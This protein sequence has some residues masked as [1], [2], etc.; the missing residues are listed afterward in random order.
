[1]AASITT[2]HMAGSINPAKSPKAKIP[3]PTANNLQVI[4]I[5]LTSI[6]SILHYMQNTKMC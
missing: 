6:A 5:L 4:C 1:M 3:A 2:S